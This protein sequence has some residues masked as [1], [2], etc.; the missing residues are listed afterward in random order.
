MEEPSG[1]EGDISQSQQYSGLKRQR[2]VSEKLLQQSNED[3][4]I[5]LKKPRKTYTSSKPRQK[6]NTKEKMKVQPAIFIPPPLPLETK[7]LPSVALSSIDK[8]RQLK[9]SE[10]Q[11]TCYGCKVS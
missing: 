7:R 4:N 3:E 11:L 9:L 1:V 6:G 2:K 5:E 8:A 10:D